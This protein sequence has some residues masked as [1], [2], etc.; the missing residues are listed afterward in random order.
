VGSRFNVN[1][2]LLGVSHTPTAGNLACRSGFVE[3][4]GTRTVTKGLGSIAALTQI[5]L[6]NNHL[7]RHLA[8]PNAARALFLVDSC[9]KSPM[10]AFP[11]DRKRRGDTAPGRRQSLFF[12]LAPADFQVA[13]LIKFDGLELRISHWQRIT[14]YGVSGA[15]LVPGVRA[16]PDAEVKFSPQFRRCRV[17]SESSPDKVWPR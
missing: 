11:V 5:L 10:T 13:D 14:G 8:S 16:L 3:R 1:P 7:D 9:C 4:A 2:V 6:I 17:P 15:E 12:S